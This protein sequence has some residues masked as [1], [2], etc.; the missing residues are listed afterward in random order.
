MKNFRP[1]AALLALSIV[2][3]AA[4]ADDV[5]AL[6]AELQAL[7][8]EY[9]ARVDALEARLVQVEAASE[10][11]AVLTESPP[12]SAAPAAAPGSGASAFNPA[13]SLIL[14]GS[15]TQASRNPESWNMAGFQPNGGEVGPGERSFNLGES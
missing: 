5:A 11:Q 12:P 9:K 4:H 2:P 15:Y 1:V 3:L 6:R 14:G 7:K 8:D 13:I 10:A